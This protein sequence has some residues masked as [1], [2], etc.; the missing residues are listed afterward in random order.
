MAASPWL[1]DPDLA[2]G[3][4]ILTHRSLCHGRQAREM[5]AFLLNCAME[6]RARVSLKETCPACRN[7]AGLSLLFTLGARK[8][9]EDT[10]AFL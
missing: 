10:Q 8:K 7:P 1:T 5:M 6:Q 9:E 3:A 4:G 2:L